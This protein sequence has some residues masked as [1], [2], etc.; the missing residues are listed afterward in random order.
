MFRIDADAGI[1][2]EESTDPSKEFAERVELLACNAAAVFAAA[3]VVTADP[4]KTGATLGSKDHKV[5]SRTT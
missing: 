3:L 4:I 2:Q 5:P 1:E